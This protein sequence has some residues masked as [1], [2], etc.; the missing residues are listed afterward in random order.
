MDQ[1]S[2]GVDLLSRPILSCVVP[3]HLCNDRG[4]L[5]SLS[6]HTRDLLDRQI[7][8]AP[9]PI[10]PEGALLLRVYI[11]TPGLENQTQNQV[12]KVR[13]GGRKRAQNA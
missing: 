9:Q 4:R 11:Y 13:K 5:V 3:I 8:I 6:D 1:S 10:H 2:S 12:Q 7:A